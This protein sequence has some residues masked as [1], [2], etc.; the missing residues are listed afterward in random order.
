[1]RAVVLRHP[2]RG[3]HLVS[4]TYES[5]CATSSPAAPRVISRA[6]RPSL[7]CLAVKIAPL[8]VGEHQCWCA[9]AG[10]FLQED[11]DDV[12]SGGDAAGGLPALLGCS[13]QN[14]FQ[15]Q[16]VACGVGNHEAA[17]GQD[18]PDRGHH[19]DFRHAGI[20]RQVVAMVSAPASKPFLAS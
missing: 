4:L 3:S 20:D 16:R 12:G 7:R 2:A 8:N 17:S 1:M 14:R 18:A 10:E 5:G 11:I 15:E 6:V 19:R 9:P 13:A